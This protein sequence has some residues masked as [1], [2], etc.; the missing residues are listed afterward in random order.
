MSNQ[1]PG[2]YHKASG[3]DSGIHINAFALIKFCKE[4]QEVLQKRGEEDSALRFEILG[5]YLRED[6]KGG[7]INTGRALGL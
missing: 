1:R 7:Q 3:A 6:Y 2:K 4:A 5:D